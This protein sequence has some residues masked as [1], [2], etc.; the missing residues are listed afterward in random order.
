MLVWVKQPENMSA[1]EF[2]DEYIDARIPALPFHHDL[3]PEAHQQRRLW[4]YVTKAI[5]HDCNDACAAM[6]VINCREVRCCSKGFP[7]T[8]SD[9]TE[10]SGLFYIYRKVIFKFRNTLH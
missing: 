7:K 3:S 4:H 1:A 10:I 6:K 9:H 5:F 8:F 2:V